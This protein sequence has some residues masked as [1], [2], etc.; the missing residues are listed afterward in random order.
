MTSTLAEHIKTLEDEVQLLQNLSFP[1]IV[2]YLGTESTGDALN[3]FLEYVP[4]GSIAS[5]VARFGCFSESVVRVYTR[6]ILMGLEY[7]HSNGIIHR[8][9]KGA[10]I[11]V[12][13][14]GLVKLADF[15]ASKRIEDIAT[16]GTSIECTA[17]F[18]PS[19]LFLLLVNRKFSFFNDVYLSSK[20]SFQ[21]MQN[22]G[23]NLSKARPIGW[24]LKS[25]KP[26]DMSDLPTFGQ[27]PAPSSKWQ[28]ESLL[29]AN[30]ASQSLQCST[31]RNPRVHPP[32]LRIYLPTV[33]TFY[34]CVS[35]AIGGNGPP[36]RSCCSTLFWRKRNAATRTLFLLLE[37]FTQNSLIFQRIEQKHR[38]E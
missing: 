6:Q 23:S 29:G 14:T 20:S 31:L 1:N 37:L 30:T 2:C 8:D 10:N 18:F 32:F 9:I 25:F 5:L 22:L 35:I 27:S 17:A 26:L 4:G 36:P 16:M 13:N 3:I 15:G 21:Q 33:K 34:T 7:L 28:L 12:D 19:S 24:L 11:L 38:E